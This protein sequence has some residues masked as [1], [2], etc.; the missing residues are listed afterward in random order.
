MGLVF[1]PSE[2][3]TWSIEKLRPYARNAKMHGDDQVP[4]SCNDV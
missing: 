2:I 4:A 3:E 1:A